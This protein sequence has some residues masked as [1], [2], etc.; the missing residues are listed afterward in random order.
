MNKRRE[1]QFKN[2][3][4]DDPATITFGSDAYPATVVA[5]RRS[6]SGTLK[7]QVTEIHVQSDEY[8]AVSGSAQDGSAKYEYVRNE[9]GAVRVYKRRRNGEF[10]EPGGWLIVGERRA[11]YDPHI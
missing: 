4:V 7:G 9:D 11:Y 8:W 6:K 3:K 2:V 10:G 5:V 1:E